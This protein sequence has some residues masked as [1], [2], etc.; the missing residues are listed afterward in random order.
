MIILDGSA[1]EGGGALVRV[2]LALSTLTHEPVKITSIRANR[3]SKGLKAQHMAAIELLRQCSDAKTNFVEVGSDHLIFYPGQMKKGRFEIDIGTAGSITLLL[4]S[5]LLPALFAPGKVT[6][7]IT[8]GTCGKFQASVTYLDKVLLPQ[9]ARFAKIECKVLKRGYFPAGGGVVELSVNPKIHGQKCK[10]I[11]ELL[12][13]IRADVAF[14]SL[15]TVATLGVVRGFVN[16]SS[17]LQEGDVGGRIRGSCEQQLKVLGVPVL[18]DVEYAGA[19]SVGG[20]VVLAA[21]FG[22]QAACPMVVG[23]DILL[24][25]NVSSEEIG[26]R[27]SQRLLGLIKEE[28]CV[29]TFLLDQLVMFAALL[30]GSVLRSSSVSSHT[31]T[32]IAV[33]EKFLP[34]RFDVKGGVVKV[35]N[36]EKSLL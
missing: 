23:A 11:I 32:N 16:M 27:V 4:Q 33:I 25:K 24:E 13:L 6:F 22:D 36:I 34:V 7:V 5:V 20:E 35:I 8:G 3:P 28:V 1:G 31:S 2:A 15:G 10:T 21:Y 26:K 30:P 19:R 14:F 17:D 29:D 18:F 12:D 9:L